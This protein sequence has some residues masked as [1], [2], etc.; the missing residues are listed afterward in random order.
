MNG[1]PVEESSQAIGRGFIQ[2]LQTAH[3]T[4]GLIRGRGGDSRSRAEHEQR[5]ELAA[6]K[7][8]RSAVE[9]QAR[10]GGLGLEHELARQRIAEVR[11]RIDN[12]A[13][14]TDVEVRHKEHQI[15]RADKDLTRRETDSELAR[16]QSR[17]V[18]EKRIS[19]YTNRETREQQL[20]DLEVQIKQSI[21]DARRRAAGFTD[22][23][24][25]PE[26]PQGPGQAAAAQFAAAD[27]VR[28]LSPDAEADATA[29]RE[30]F[31]DDTG[32][33]PEDLFDNSEFA[34][35][36]DSWSHGLGD[37][38]GLAEDLTMSAHFRHEFGYSADDPDTYVDVEIVDISEVIDSAVTATAVHDIDPSA[39]DPDLTVA[40]GEGGARV[41][42]TEIEL[43]RPQPD[44]GQGR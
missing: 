34:E 31:V 14:V 7:D 18:H 5:V 17:E 12:A 1:D 30:R 37:I 35:V 24:Y 39:P 25:R 26:N 41:P 2:A 27:A 44:L 16:D 33:E 4:S 32:I 36:S 38:T 42:G 8:V 40:D 11:A 22:S 20:H 10:L 15:T 29:Y 21:L 23:L 19:S 6:A 9:H 3:T 28:D 43:W 13:R